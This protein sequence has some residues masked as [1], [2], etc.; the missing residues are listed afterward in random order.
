MDDTWVTVDGNQGVDQ[1]HSKLLNMALATIEKAREQ[2][3]G[4]LYD[5]KLL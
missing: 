5:S 4:R 1:V 3:L 2:P